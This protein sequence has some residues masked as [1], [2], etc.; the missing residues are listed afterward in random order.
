MFALSAYFSI[1]VLSIHIQWNKLHAQQL[2]TIDQ[3]HFDSNII[4]DHQLII[5]LDDS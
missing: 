5:M 4:I 1:I 3:K 2:R